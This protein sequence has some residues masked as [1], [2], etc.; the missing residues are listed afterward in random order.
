MSQKCWQQLHSIKMIEKPDTLILWKNK[1]TGHKINYGRE[2]ISWGEHHLFAAEAA[3]DSDPAGAGQANWDMP[4][5]CTSWTSPQRWADWQTGI[6]GLHVTDFI[7]PTLLQG[8]IWWADS[9][10]SCTCHLSNLLLGAVPPFSNSQNWSWKADRFLE[11]LGSISG[12]LI[13]LMNGISQWA[14]TTAPIIKRLSFPFSTDQAHL[15]CVKNRLAV[16]FKEVILRQAL[17]LYP[18][19]GQRMFPPFLGSPLGSS[20]R[21]SAVWVV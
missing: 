1:A 5:H 3:A 6:K 21:H 8:N 9:V 4:G 19:R 18:E 17:L 14:H 10:H 20:I 15:L 16:I 13:C 11:H 7:F 2:I 12:P